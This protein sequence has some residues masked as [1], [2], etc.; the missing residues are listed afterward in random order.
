VK[1]PTPTISATTMAVATIAETA[2]PLSESFPD[3]AALP[4]SD[5]VM[6]VH[7]L[8]IAP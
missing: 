4:V 7:A 2:E 3:G 8:G 1:T 5:L 6:L